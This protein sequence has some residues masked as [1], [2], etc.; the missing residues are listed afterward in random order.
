MNKY[1]VYLEIRLDID[2]ESPE[3]AKEAASR[4][5][6]ESFFGNSDTK[7]QFKKENIE[8]KEITNRSFEVIF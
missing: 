3:K 8:F 2:A 6:G 7:L 1:S 5:Y 4:W